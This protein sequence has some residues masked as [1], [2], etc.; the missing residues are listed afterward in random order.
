MKETKE[1]VLKLA[2]QKLDFLSPIMVR[3]DNQDNNC[4]IEVL[5]NSEFKFYILCTSEPQDIDQTLL[6]V[7]ETLKNEGYSIHNNSSGHL[8]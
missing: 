6:L 5:Q 3:I 7:K 1:L 2:S 4:Y 8:N